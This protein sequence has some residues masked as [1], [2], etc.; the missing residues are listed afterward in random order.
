M[1]AAIPWAATV[2]SPLCS[3]PG[4]EIAGAACAVDVGRTAA[5]ARAP[6]AH[7]KDK[8]SRVAPYLDLPVMGVRS[9]QFEG[10]PAGAMSEHDTAMRTTPVSFEPT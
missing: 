6:A 4:R 9:F 3:R 5:P 2:L 10:Q 8:V 1:T 7:I